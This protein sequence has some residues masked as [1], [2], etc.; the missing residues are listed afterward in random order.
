RIIAGVLGGVP[1]RPPSA[2]VTHLNR[3]ACGV[4]DFGAATIYDLDPVAVGADLLGRGALVLAAGFAALQKLGVDLDTCRDQLER[5]DLAYLA[6]A[7]RVGG[8]A[9][10]CTS[11]WRYREESAEVQHRELSARAAALITEHWD[12]IVQEAERLLAERRPTRQ[13][14]A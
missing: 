6:E 3:S 12:A 1:L 2:R 11:S 13:K 5:W 9:A 7:A 8:F 4:I 14:R 10:L